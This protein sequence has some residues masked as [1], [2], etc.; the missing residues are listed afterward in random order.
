M[1]KKQRLYTTAFKLK[2]V[3]EIEAGKYSCSSASRKYGIGG[4]TTVSKWLKRFGKGYLVD[5]DYNI[6]MSKKGDKLAQEK[7]K[8]RLLQAALAESQMKIIALEALVD[9]ASEHYGTNL[10]KNFADKALKKR[11]RKKRSR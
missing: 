4:K 2:V 9:V 7:E 10:K 5:R 1:T 8:N 3:S 11:V 6:D